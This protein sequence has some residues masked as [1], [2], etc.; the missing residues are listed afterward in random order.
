MVLD[1]YFIKWSYIPKGGGYVSQGKYKENKYI[2]SIKT[3]IDEGLEAKA[4]KYHKGHD[5]CEGVNANIY[6]KNKY[7]TKFIFDT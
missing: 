6:H 1:L 2:Q 5:G 4:V 7:S 3:L